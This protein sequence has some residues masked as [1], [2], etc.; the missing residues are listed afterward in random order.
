MPLKLDVNGLTIQSLSEIR[1]EL[2]Q[3]YKDKYGKGHLVDEKSNTGKKIGIYAEREALIQEIIEAVYLSAYI[4]TAIGVSLDRVIEITGIKRKSGIPS[5]VPSMYAAGTP[6]TSVLV[7]EL[8]I[9]V[10]Q[11]GELFRNTE[12][13]TLGSLSQETA[14]S[15]VRSGTTVTVTI[16][17][18]HSFTEDSWVFINGADQEEYN[19]LAQIYNVTGTT[20]DYT[21]SGDLPVSPATGTITVDEATNFRAESV[22][23]GEIVALQGTLTVIEIAVAGID[24]VENADDAIEGN[25]TESDAEVREDYPS[26][27]AALG[28]GTIEAIKAR[29]L[30]IL[31]VSSASVFQNV[32]DE[33]DS[34]GR[35]PHSVESFVL[36]P[37][38]DDAEIYQTM[39][40]SVSA[41][42][43]QEGNQTSVIAD[44]SGN[45]QPVAFSRLEDVG[46][47]VDITV[48]TNADPNQGPVFIKTDDVGLNEIIDNLTSIDYQPGQNV[49]QSTLEN[50]VIDVSGVISVIAKFDKT[51][52]P[53]NIAPIEIL[54]GEVA[55]I[56]SGDI[57]G[58]IDGTPI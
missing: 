6:S 41:G 21:I 9:S 37:G 15:V 10:E 32:T 18:G 50:A 12:D 33:I 51:S 29:L 31:T 35:R 30:E 19:V 36:S 20:F 34:A 39:L 5:S 14:S 27:L 54:S 4:G 13:F 49:W 2:E 17:G 57:T 25:L 8:T 53:T 52:S 55:N 26:K 47:Y 48:V 16:S 43:R 7:G 38:G 46:I 44:S 42:I 3:A 56:D 23:N 58:T 11:S 40:E 45:P 1:T 28:G 24:Q 22:E